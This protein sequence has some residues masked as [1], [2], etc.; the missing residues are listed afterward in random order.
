MI[1]KE[2]YRLIS[3]MNIDERFSTKYWQTILNNTSRRSYTM[4]KLISFQGAR[5]VQHT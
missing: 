1:R 3:L 2:N 4:T 5:V